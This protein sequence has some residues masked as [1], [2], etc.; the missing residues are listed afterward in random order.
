MSRLLILRP[1]V[2]SHHEGTSFNLY[3]YGNSWLVFLGKT[4]ETA[5]EHDNK[6]NCKV[7]FHRG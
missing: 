2:I 7:L 3:H 5:R 4:H 1:L 6:Y